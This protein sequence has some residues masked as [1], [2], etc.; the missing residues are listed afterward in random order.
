MGGN[1]R[2]EAGTTGRPG[3]SGRGRGGVLYVYIIYRVLQ[4]RITERALAREKSFFLQGVAPR[5]GG[6][7]GIVAAAADLHAPVVAFFLM[8]FHCFFYAFCTPSG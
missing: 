1:P 6:W 7:G 2:S 5:G 4:S 8:I 3:L